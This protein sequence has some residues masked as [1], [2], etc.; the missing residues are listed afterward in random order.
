MNMKFIL[1]VV[2][3]LSLGFIVP[4]KVCAQSFEREENNIWLNNG[5]GLNF[6]TGAPVAQPSSV[7]TAGI[8]NNSASVCDANGHLLF[9][10]DGNV[11]W[12]K[13]NDIMQNGWDIN[14]DGNM[15]PNT[16]FIE[17][18]FG[19]SSYSF[20]GVIIIPMPGS[21]HKYYI[22]S[23]PMIWVQNT[24]GLYSNQ[25]Q[26]KL[27]CTVVDMESNNGLGAVDPEH[28][29]EVVAEE[30]AG[31]LHAVIGE[32]CNYWLL[33]FGSNGSYKAFNITAEGM[34]TTPVVSTLTPPLNPFVSE[35]NI[36]PNRQR[37]AMA[38]NAEVQIS[39]FDPAT[40]QFSNDISIGAQDCNH[41]AFSP[42]SNLIYFS[43]IIGLRQYDLT[44]LS[45]PFTLLSINNITAYEADAP[46]RLGP[47]GKIYFSYCTVASGN[48]AFQGAA[49]MQPDIFG[50][51][52]QMELLTN[53]QLPLINGDWYPLYQLPNEI[54][55]QIY[56]TISTVKEVPLCFNIPVK[57]K[58]DV[59]QATD[60]HWMVNT[61]GYTYIRN[62]SDTSSSLLATAPGKY[63]VQYFTTN[64][65]AL[66]R[67]TFI[68]NKVNFS[69]YLGADKISC[70]GEPITLEAGVPGGNYL[71]SDNST[72]KE[73]QA[74]T[75]GLYWVQVSQGGC[76]ATDS[77]NVRILDIKQ[78]LGKDTTLCMEDPDKQ[79]VLEASL[80]AGATA[81]WNTGSTDPLIRV[82]DSGLYWV[83][84][85]IQDCVGADSVFI[86][87]QYCDC[88][89]LFPTAFSPNSDG[90][91]DLYM[92]TIPAACP[93]DQFK[94]QIYNRW[95]QLV[96]VS[97]KPYEGWN[98][99]YNGQ[100]ADVGN[101]MYRLQMK[102]GTRKKE[103][104]KNGDFMLIR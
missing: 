49:V 46:L 76:T 65:C 34:N 71:W 91:N 12:N 5:N 61:V 28:K 32:D 99:I 63:A 13:N 83:T 79:I 88:P 82:A 11:V 40:G 23:S 100:P 14:N 69:L 22:F 93:V 48:I 39:D 67:D 2:I 57:L 59:T 35:L 84:V 92:P 74:S 16:Y 24:I 56:D 1:C 96:F 62:G 55:V 72:G 81:L 54:P 21:S 20:D 19:M 44:N 75:S 43:G 17:P 90:V 78:N 80:P 102:T 60:Y 47:D 42:N 45:I 51:G 64:P 85:T 9:Y 53:Q 68:V 37:A 86:H 3:T 31:N 58:P 50:P 89:L 6:N 25:W 33:A 95:G 41:A 8:S 73:L 4:A 26:G 94:L 104:F 66:H 97:Y 70:N 7:Q 30:L 27:Y 18:A 10:T 87:K 38:L 52:C 101:Y 103:I 29:G 77:I 15:A 36:S 98:G